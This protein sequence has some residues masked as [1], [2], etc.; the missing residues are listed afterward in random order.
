MKNGQ[1]LTYNLTNKELKYHP[2]KN[3]PKQKQN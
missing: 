2:T 1:Q 3:I